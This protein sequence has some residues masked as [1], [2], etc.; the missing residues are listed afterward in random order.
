MKFETGL[1]GVCAAA[2]ILAVGGAAHAEDTAKVEI[3]VGTGEHAEPKHEAGKEE[4]EEPSGAVAADM[5][6]GFGKVASWLPGPAGVSASGPGGPAGLTS[7]ASRVTTEGFL[8]GAE[9]RVFKHTSIGFR[10]PISIGEFDVPGGNDFRSTTAIGNLE[11]ALGYE[12]EI[13]EHV[14]FLFD[15]GFALPTAQGQEIP[16][17][18]DQLEALQTNPGAYD[19]ASLNHAV[20]LSRGGE[21]TALY[22]IKR[23]GIIPKVGVDYHAKGLFVT[24]S[25]KVE[26]MISVVSDATPKY[27]GELVP[28]VGVGYRVAPHVVPEL[29]MFAPI[30]FSGAAADEKKAGFVLEPQIVMPFGNV[31]PVVGVYVPVAGPAADP[32]FIGIRVGVVAAF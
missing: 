5:V 31:R 3:S 2:A 13:A 1:L 15:L 6:L 19:K 7:G 32:Q 23:F 24:A 4:E 25:V 28:A 20:S 8:L 30:T 17:N 26:N 11:L 14:G 9:F 12:R 16:D 29:R 10:F 22:E 18:L 27:L 21:D